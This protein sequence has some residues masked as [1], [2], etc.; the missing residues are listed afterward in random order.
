M[1]S[2]MKAAFDNVNTEV[3]EMLNITA[4]YNGYNYGSLLIKIESEQIQKLC[5]IKLISGLSLQKIVIINLKKFNEN[6]NFEMIDRIKKYYSLHKGHRE[7]TNKSIG[8]TT[9]QSRQ[10]VDKLDLIIAE[11]CDKRKCS[12]WGLKSCIIRFIVDRV[13]N[14]FEKENPTVDLLG[15]QYKIN[16]EENKIADE[17]KEHIVGTLSIEDER[18]EN[19]STRNK[20]NNTIE[21][22]SD[23]MGFAKDVN[24]LL[25]KFKHYKLIQDRV[26]EF[27]KDIYAMSKE[28]INDE[29]RTFDK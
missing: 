10:I 20:I 21:V 14:D 17:T 9:L 6:Y 13:I 2:T 28:I 12:N 24:D 15:I 3:M 19:A 26:D 27:V 5:S 1:A 8:L 18:T 25:K 22:V 29:A 11:Y 23:L 16:Q 7:V 4:S